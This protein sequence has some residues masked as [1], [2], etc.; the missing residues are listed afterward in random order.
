MTEHHFEAMGTHWCL[1]SE[2]TTEHV[3]AERYV[4]HCES[5]FSRFLPESALSRLNAHR[6]IKHADLAALISV[7]L[8]MRTV[9]GGAFDPTLGDQLRSL[10]Y[11]RS[12]A[13]NLTAGPRIGRSSLLVH[14]DGEFIELEGDGTVDLGGIAKGWT[15]DKV[16]QQLRDDTRDGVLVDGGGDIRVIDGSWRIGVG[17]EYHVTLS[18]GAVATSSTRDRRWT[19]GLHHI[20]DPC[21][22][23]STT[24]NIE[25]A[26]VV[27]SD[28]THADALATAL[29]VNPSLVKDPDLPL[30]QAMYCDRNGHWWTTPNWSDAP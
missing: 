15:V 25:I 9:T 28:A 4:R 24:T 19:R 12:F 27:A 7:A 30:T 5:V 16:A 11:D 3:E 6:R 17:D 1:I 10:G 8:A 2:A 20:V 29:I 23:S 26:T 21:E 13:P 22:G 14:T 18:R